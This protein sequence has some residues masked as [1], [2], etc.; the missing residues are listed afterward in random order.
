M[1]SW[2]PGGRGAGGGTARARR[3]AGGGERGSTSPTRNRREFTTS[4][5]SRKRASRSSLKRESSCAHTFVAARTT[6][7]PRSS[8][9]GRAR[10]AMREPTASR[11]A[12]SEM[13]ALV[14]ANLASLA[15]SRVTSIFSGMT[16]FDRR[17]RDRMPSLSR[18]V[19][20][21]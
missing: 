17:G 21:G 1:A 7:I 10:S 8:S 16:S 18:L 4:P 20:P 9:T 3:V 14:R 12:R 6:R 5:R 13:G 19:R 2:S 11:Q 15:R